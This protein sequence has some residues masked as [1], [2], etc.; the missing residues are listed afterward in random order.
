MGTWTR[1]LASPAENRWVS[2]LY[3]AARVGVIPGDHVADKRPTQP[4]QRQSARKAMPVG[5]RALR[6]ACTAFSVHVPHNQV[7]SGNS[8]RFRLAIDCGPGDHR[9]GTDNDPLLRAY[10]AVESGPMRLRTV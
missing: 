1:R 2:G 10:K 7:F 9:L 6:Y 3:L 5:L 8:G 4:C